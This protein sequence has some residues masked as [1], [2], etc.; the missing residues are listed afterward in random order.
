MLVRHDEVRQ[1]RMQAAALKA[2]AARD[3]QRDVDARFQKDMALPM[4]VA[5]KRSTAGRADAL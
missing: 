3:K 2:A 4:V 5:A 1:E